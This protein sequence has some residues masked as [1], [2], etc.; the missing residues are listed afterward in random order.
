MLVRFRHLFENLHPLMGH[1]DIGL[2]T[3]LGKGGYPALNFFLAHGHF[4]NS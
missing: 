1:S 3:G 2:F 4:I